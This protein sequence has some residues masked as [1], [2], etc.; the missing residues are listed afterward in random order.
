MKKLLLV[1]AISLILTGCGNKNIPSDTAISCGE[2]TID[3]V[4]DYLDG[5]TDYSSVIDDLDKITDEL[6]YINESDDY[7][8]KDFD[9][10]ISI[11]NLKTKIAGYNLHND[12][13]SKQEIQKE[14]TELSN[15]IK[16]D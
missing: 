5:E 13:D 15:I 1:I 9:V 6:D 11:S 3:A 7:N 14:L 10:L 8:A 4:N 12:T 2:R 16:G